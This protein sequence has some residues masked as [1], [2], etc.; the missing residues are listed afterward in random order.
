MQKKKDESLNSDADFSPARPR[1]SE[2]NPRNRFN[3][4]GKIPVRAHQISHE[5]STPS[6]LIF[7]SLRDPSCLTRALAFSS[8]LFRPFR[9]RFWAFRILLCVKL[10]VKTGSFLAFCF[11]AFFAGSSRSCASS[12]AAFA[13]RPELMP[14]VRSGK[15]W[16]SAFIFCPPGLGIESSGGLSGVSRGLLSRGEAP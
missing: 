7:F 16:G 9:R 10:W 6:A 1:N 11:L 15:S 14:G 2:T 4:N 5:P 13:V 12:S 8:R 3:R